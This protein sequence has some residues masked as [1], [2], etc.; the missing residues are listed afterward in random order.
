MVEAQS[1]IT[2]IYL[3]SNSYVEVNEQR[4]GFCDK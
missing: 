4:S 2:T 1:F 3:M